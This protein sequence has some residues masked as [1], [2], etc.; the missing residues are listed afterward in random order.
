MPLRMLDSYSVIRADEPSACVSLTEA[1]E[2][3]LMLRGY[4]VAPAG[5]GKGRGGAG[6]MAAEQCS[7]GQ[8]QPRWAPCTAACGWGGAACHGVAAFLRRPS[9]GDCTGVTQRVWCWLL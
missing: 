3:E 8:C 5:K 2:Q 7:A 9:P 4:V 6:M 1:K